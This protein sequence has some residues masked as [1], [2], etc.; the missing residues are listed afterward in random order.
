MLILTNK[1]SH[2]C[3]PSKNDVPAGCKGTGF[4]YL[5]RHEQNLNSARHFLFGLVFGFKFCKTFSFWSCIW[6]SDNNYIWLDI[7][8]AYSVSLNT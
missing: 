1:I 8:L 5:K 4:C 2:C 6:V 3:F 7:K